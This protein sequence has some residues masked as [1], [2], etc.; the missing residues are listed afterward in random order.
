MPPV[1]GIIG[2]IGSTAA[3]VAP[4]VIGGIQGYKAVEGLLHK[5]KAPSAAAPIA[6]AA[7]TDDFQEQRD[8]TIKTL[9]GII[10]RQGAIER[11]SAPPAQVIYAAPQEQKTAPNYVLYGMIAFV[12]Y[13]LLRKK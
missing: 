13:L 9:A 8:T 6:A 2:A 10:E 1:A 11:Q 4:T 5:P 12:G 3:A 7:Q